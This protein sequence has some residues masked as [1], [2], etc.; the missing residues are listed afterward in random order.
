MVD[1]MDGYRFRFHEYAGGCCMMEDTL[2]EFDSIRLPAELGR[3]L[4]EM[5]GEQHNLRIEKDNQFAKLHALINIAENSD[6]DKDVLI[7]CINNS[8]D[9]K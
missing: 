8:G 1:K 3:V 9:F 5:L 6:L 4:A 2:A 7:A